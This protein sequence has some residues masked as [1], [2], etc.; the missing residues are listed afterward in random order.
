MNEQDE[1]L[2][3]Y[4]RTFAEH[5]TSEEQLAT[6]FDD[7]PNVDDLG[8]IILRLRW[9]LTTEKRMTFQAIADLFGMKR[10]RVEEL[11]NVGYEHFAEGY[12]K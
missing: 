4:G 9:G 11:A 7:I 6:L 5:A 10:K 2:R 1:I 8:K 3:R 12:K